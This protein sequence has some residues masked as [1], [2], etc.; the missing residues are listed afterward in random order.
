MGCFASLCHIYYPFSNVLKGS[1]DG[2]SFFYYLNFVLNPVC[3]INSDNV[4]LFGMLLVLFQQ[5]MMPHS[6]QS[7]VSLSDDGV[8]AVLQVRIETNKMRLIAA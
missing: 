1:I 7:A 3:H 5:L 4:R 8:G 6:L 2:D